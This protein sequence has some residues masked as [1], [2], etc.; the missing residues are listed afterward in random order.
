MFASLIALLP[1]LAL[2]PSLTL[3]APAVPATLSKRAVGTVRNCNTQGQIAITFDD[4]PFQYDNDLLNTL[5]DNKATFFINGQ[6][7]GCIYDY[8]DDLKRMSA[9]GHTI[10]S[11]TWSHKDLT[12]LS[13]DQ[14]HDEF[15]RVEDA[16]TKI[17]G[18]KPKYFRPPFGKYN[19]QVL[20]V[21]AQRG[22]TKMILWSDDTQDASG[23]PV[24]QS[25]QTYDNINGQSG[26][27]VLNHNVIPG[28]VY[29]VVPH[30]LSVT[31]SLQKVSIDTCLGS[32]GEWPYYWVQNPGNRDGSWTC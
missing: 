26:R 3:A 23:A 15:Y 18:L 7:Y 17:L 2:T 21:A 25:K 24:W 22:Y 12:T 29:D 5:G 30:A 31:G 27:I 9:A 8:A 10:G 1:L 6:N 14:L 16:M 20:Q 19:D 4:G 13:W 32:E 28:T 11:H